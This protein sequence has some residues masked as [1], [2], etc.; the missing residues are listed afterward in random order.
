M[1][2]N[3]IFLEQYTSDFRGEKYEV[4]KFID[5]ITLRIFYGSNLSVGE[6]VRGKTYKGTLD[7]KSFNGQDKIK[8]TSIKES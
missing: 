7:I 6:L 1:N 4:Y 5:E 3:L 2:R 8:V